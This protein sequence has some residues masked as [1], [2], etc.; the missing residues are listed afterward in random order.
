MVAVAVAEHSSDFV[1]H[2]ELAVIPAVIILANRV[3]LVMQLQIQVVVV[4]GML[5]AEAEVRAMSVA[6]FQERAAT[7]S[8]AF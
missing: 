8:F 6:V 7:V 2:Q 3:L 1:L 4:L 5:A